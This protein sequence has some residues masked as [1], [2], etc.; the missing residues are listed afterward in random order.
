M[1]G[2]LGNIVGKGGWLGVTF[3]NCIQRGVVPIARG[4]FGVREGRAYGILNVAQGSL[5]VAVLGRR[6]RGS[7]KA[8]YSVLFINVLK[9][10]AREFFCVVAYGTLG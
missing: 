6:V 1:K 7:C 3:G 4:H 9:G 2:V 10:L 5:S 8:V